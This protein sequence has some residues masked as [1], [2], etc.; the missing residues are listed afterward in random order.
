M[1]VYEEDGADLEEVDEDAVKNQL[2]QAYLRRMLDEDQDELKR[3][4]N[5]YLEDGEYHS[6]EQRERKFSWKFDA[7]G[8]KIVKI[9][10]H[11]LLNLFTKNL[12]FFPLFFF[13]S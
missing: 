1:D 2:E 9:L 6:E 7:A 10:T 5:R 4:Q 8:K 13:Q 12:T 11:F 3:L